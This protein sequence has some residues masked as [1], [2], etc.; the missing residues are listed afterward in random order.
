[1]IEVRLFAHFR[2]NRDKVMFLSAHDFDNGAAIIAHLGISPEEVSIFLINGRH[3]TLAAPL[4][5]G[6]IVALFPPAGGG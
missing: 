1:M 5:A 4:Q 2:H 6:D 3:S